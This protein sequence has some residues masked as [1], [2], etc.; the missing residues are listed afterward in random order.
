M[1]QT[2]IMTDAG[3]VRIG[4]VIRIIDIYDK[5]T[6][7]AAFPDGIDH[8][9]S[10]LVGKTGEVTLID[11]TGSL[12]GTWGSLAVLPEVDTFEIIG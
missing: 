7:S 8:H 1:A 4:T 3:L 12:H 5:A 6:P 9:A 11:D 10:A 2:S